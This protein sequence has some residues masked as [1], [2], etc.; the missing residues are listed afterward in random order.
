MQ[1]TTRRSML[2]S[3]AA[4]PF[5]GCLFKREAKAEPPQRDERDELIELLWTELSLTKRLRWIDDFS[6]TA[7][8][9]LRE[10]AES[11]CAR[12]RYKAREGHIAIGVRVGDGDRHWFLGTNELDALTRAL[13]YFKIG[14]YQGMT[15]WHNH[16]AMM[17][18]EEKY[19]A[20]SLRYFLSGEEYALEHMAICCR[21]WIETA[22]AAGGE[23]DDVVA[24][25][26]AIL[27][28]RAKND[29]SHIINA[30]NDGDD[31]A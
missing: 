6:R 19:I 3:L 1:T 12:I 17:A 7:H 15:E 27:A 18:E 16:A 25:H 5:V 9:V 14:G 31:V 21:G 28:V 30:I 10:W 8:A 24:R 13:A 29:C 26:L 11:N 23:C 20:T 4:L 22:R 2:K